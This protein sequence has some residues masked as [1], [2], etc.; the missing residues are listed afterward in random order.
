MH[1]RV[2]ASLIEHLE[3]L[4]VPTLKGW[5]RRVDAL[6][7]T[8]TLRAQFA[9]AIE[10]QLASNLPKLVS[11]LSPSETALLAESAHRGGLVSSRVFMAKYRGKYTMPK[12]GADRDKPAW[13]LAPFIHS[14]DFRTGAPAFLIPSL[15]DPLCALLPKPADLKV[16]TVNTLPKTEP[17]RQ[18]EG[19][20]LIRPVHIFESE[21]IALVELT[22][23]LR[24]VQS[25]K[26]KVTDATQR[27]T[28]ATTRLVGQ[29]LVSGDFDLEIPQSHRES[30]ADL[31]HYQPAGA[32]RAHA[33]PV[34][35]Q[36]CGWARSKSGVLALTDSGKDILQ[37]FTAEKLRAGVLRCMANSD[38][39]ELNRVNNIRGQSGKTKH[40]LSPP[41]VR[42][43]AIL[44]SLNAWPAQRWLEYREARRVAEASPEH[45]D[46]LLGDYA[47]LYLCELRYG[48]IFPSTDLNSQFIRAFFL[49]TLAT[50]GV[51]D[52][53]YVFP[54]HL[55]PDLDDNWGMTATHFCGRYD[56]LL[57]VR[58][59][60]LGSYLLGLSDRY[61][62][63]VEAAPKLFR[64][65]PSLELV[66][67]SGP[68]NPGDRATLELLA[69][70]QS[71]QVWKLDAERILSHVQAGGSFQELS[72]F[73]LAG[74]LDDVPGT[75][76][77]FLGEL[78]SKLGACL[79]RRE[80][81]LLEWRDPSL[82]RLIADSSGA[83][84]LCYHAGENRLVVPKSSLRA[85]TRAVNKL[86]YAVPS[87]E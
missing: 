23:V 81:V 35:V 5:L 79:A 17:E 39:D 21:R 34:L 69:L 54:H 4:G 86:G 6:D 75:V 7:K 13:L 85:F 3:S 46:V 62:A 44:K 25:G 45:W 9:Q 47:G 1:G 15:V 61:E 64:V 10:Q 40:V 32:V 65:L 16:R 52:V 49:E 2:Q 31:E 66:A 70:P 87:G 53:A 55:W 8:R 80:S 84:S 33:W 27:P 73:L 50:L 60:P 77:A 68:L 19:D 29:T 71:D 12:L 63:S 26:I 43:A 51:L 74:A 18:I 59:N 78:E 57:Y 22:R 24:L 11:M 38:F 37:E 56:G 48:S 30:R 36:Q 76:R 82:A 67:A 83:S 42:K 72:A 14:A 28:D 58:L 20:A 41:A